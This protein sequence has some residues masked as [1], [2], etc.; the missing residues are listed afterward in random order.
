MIDACHSYMYRFLYRYKGKLKKANW[1][2]STAHLTAAIL[3]EKYIAFL[4]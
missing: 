1:Y 4:L 2:I 3:T